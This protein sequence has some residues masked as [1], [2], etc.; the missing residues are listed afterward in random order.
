MLDVL[1]EVG[2][3]WI[4]GRLTFAERGLG[5]APAALNA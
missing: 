3:E 1:A 4:R 2:E 5:P